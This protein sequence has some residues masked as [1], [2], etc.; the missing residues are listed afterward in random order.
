VLAF[1]MG[2]GLLLSMLG[3]IYPALRAAALDPTEALRHE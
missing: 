2:M 3:G 1:G